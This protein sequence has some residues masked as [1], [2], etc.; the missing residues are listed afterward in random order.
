MT[1]HRAGRVELMHPVMLSREQIERRGK[2]I[3]EVEWR[4]TWFEGIKS[5]ADYVVAIVAVGLWYFNDSLPGRC[6]C[7][8]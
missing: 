6:N 2:K 3:T 1:H 8:Q 7:P 5:T 4:R